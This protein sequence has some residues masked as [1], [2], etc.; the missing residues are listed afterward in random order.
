MLASNPK[1]IIF[2]TNVVSEL[3]RPRPNPIV[4]AWAI[5]QSGPDVYLTTTIEGEFWAWAETQAKG[6]RRDQL[7]IGINAMIEGYFGNRVLEYDRQAARM[8]AIIYAERQAARKPILSADCQIAA[9][10]RLYG[11]AVATRDVEGFEGCGIKVINP[12]VAKPHT[13]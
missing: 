11:A 6:K 12:W 3:L 13:H 5:A 1:G 2:D 7:F 8:F 9:I 10:A 4:E